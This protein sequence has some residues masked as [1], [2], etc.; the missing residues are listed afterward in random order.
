METIAIKKLMA[1]DRFCCKT[2]GIELLDAA[3]GYAK[4][5]LDIEERH[6]NAL[7]TVQGG[8]IFTLADLAIAA[9]SNSHG[10]AAVLINASISYI[11]AV[12]TGVLYAEAKEESLNPKLATYQVRVTDQTGDLV[13]S[14]QGTVYRKKETL[15]DFL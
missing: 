12:S 8:C 13:A 2:V 7:N 1:G 11:K 14:F 10:T 6:L 15:A 4:V 9:A 5:K 3:P